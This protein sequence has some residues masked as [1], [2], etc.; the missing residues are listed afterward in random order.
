MTNL[1]TVGLTH[2]MASSVDRMFD[3]MFNEF[4][5]KRTRG[6]SYEIK[7][8]DDSVYAEVEVPGVNPKDVT[9]RVEGRA[10]HVETPRGTT[11]FTVGARVDGDNVKASVKHGMLTLT[12]PKRQAKTVAVVVEDDN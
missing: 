7:S 11:Y 9:V 2:P 5:T 1:T 10:I 4:P 6:L 8:D 12:I 3:A